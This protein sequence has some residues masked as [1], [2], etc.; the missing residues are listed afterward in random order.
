[1]CCKIVSFKKVNLFAIRTLFI[2]NKKHGLC[3]SQ[4]LEHV[5]RR[6][7]QSRAFENVREKK[8][9]GWNEILDVG[10]D[11]LCDTEGGLSLAWGVSSPTQ[12]WIQYQV[13]L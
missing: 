8:I 11:G 2:Q 5:Y 12:G 6:R 10:A 9:D 13:R 1:M 4:G 3:P 7:Q